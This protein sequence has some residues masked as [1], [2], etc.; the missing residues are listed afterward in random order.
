MVLLMDK[1]SGWTSVLLMLLLHVSLL[2]VHVVHPVLLPASHRMLNGISSGRT[3]QSWLMLLLIVVIVWHVGM[4]NPLHGSHHRLSV[5]NMVRL[6]AMGEVVV[7]GMKHV[8]VPAHLMMGRW[9]MVNHTRC[10][11]G[12]H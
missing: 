2:H 3:H 5:S 1:V 9:W 11:K 7:L 8:V 6:R 4:I 10:P 12:C